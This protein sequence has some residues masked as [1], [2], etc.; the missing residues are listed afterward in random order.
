MSDILRSNPE[1]IVELLTVFRAD[2]PTE[3]NLSKALTNIDTVLK[4][5]KISIHDKVEMYQAYD[6]FTKKF[7]LGDKPSG[8]SKSFIESLV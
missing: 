5:P 6:I 2:K 4:S 3:A 1:N 8:F 7:L